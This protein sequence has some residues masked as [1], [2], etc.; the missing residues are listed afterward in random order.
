M[1]STRWLIV[2]VCAVLVFQAAFVAPSPAAA[3]E[4]SAPVVQPSPALEPSQP[5][6]APVT[7][8]ESPRP[9]PST[10]PADDEIVPSEAP[11]TERTDMR[12][13]ASRTFEQAD[14]TFISELFSDAIFY[15]PEGSADWQPIDLTFAPT[16]AEGATAAVTRAPAQ[17][18]LFGADAAEGFLRLTGDGHSLR[19]S[20]PEGTEP[21]MAGTRPQIMENGAYVDYADFLPGGIGL[22]VFPRADGFKSFFVIPSRPA[23]NTFSLRIDAPGLSLAPDAER[24][25]DLVFRDSAGQVVGRIPRPFMLDSSVLETAEGGRGGGL[26]SEAV[27]QTAM[28]QADGSYLLTL[29]V[30]PAFLDSAVYPV[31]VDPTTT[32]FPTGATTAN[33]TFANSQTP[34]TNYN[35]YQR[36]DSPFYNEQWHGNTPGTAYYNEVYIRFNDIAETLG[37][38]LITDTSLQLYPYWQYNHSE[39]RSSWVERIAE[40]WGPGTLDWNDRPATDM[41]IGEFQTKEDVWSD[42][43]L[44]AYVQDVVNGTYPN[45]GLMLHANTLGSG[46]W[47]RIVSSN[48]STLK[49]KLVVSWTA[50]AGPTV[51]YPN[52]GGET[53]SRTLTWSLPAS[54]TQSAFEVQLDSDTG[55]SPTVYSSG[56]IS[57]TPGTIPA[58]MIPT[59]TTLTEGSTYYWRVRVKYGVNTTF[60][61]WSSTNGSFVYRQGATLGLPGHNT[62]ESFDLGSGDSALANVSTGNLVI[63]HPIVSLPVRG[64]AFDLSLTYNSHST[65]N[66]GTGPGWR[67]N[68]MR[69]LAE[70][71]NGDVV[72]TAADGSIHT[73]TK[74]STVGTVTT[75]TRPSTVYATL[76]KDTS[77]ANEWKLVYRDQSVDEFNLVSS[78]GLLAKQADRHGNAITFAY[79]TSSNRLQTATDPAGRVVDFAWNTGVSPARLTSITDWAYVSGGVIQSTATGSRREYR[80][81][82]DSNGYLIGWSNPLNTSGSCPTMASNLTCLAYTNNLLTAITKR[83]TIATLSGGAIGTSSRDISTQVTY[84]GNEVAEVRDAEQANAS[85]TGTTFT[86]IADKQLRVVRQGTPASTTTYG[87][88]SSTDNLG[89]VE[90]VWRKLGSTDIEQLTTWSSTYPTEPA[91]VTDNADAALST[92]ARTVSYTY[93]DPP[94]MGLVKQITAPLTGTTSKTTEYTYNANNDV[95]QIIVAGPSGSTTTRYCYTTSGCSTSATDLTLKSVIESYGDGSKGGSGGNATDV[96]TDYLYDANGLLTLETRWNYDEDGTLLDSRAIGYMY[97]TNNKG[98]RVKTITNYVSGTVTSPGEDV[99][100]NSSTGAYTDL[101]TVHGFDTAGNEISVE[102]PRRGIAV[103]TGQPSLVADDYVTRYEYDALNRQTRFQIARDPIDTATPKFSTA[104]YDELGATREATDLGGLVSA[105]N[106]DR[107]GRPL[108]TYEDPVGAS[109]VE[110]SVSTYDAAGRLQT[111]KDRR[112]IGSAS[113]GW[114]NFAYDALGRLVTQTEAHSGDAGD[115][116]VTTQSYDGLDRRT[117]LVSGAGAMGQTTTYRYDLGGRV[118]EQDDEFTCTRTTYD[119]R[120]L[121]QTAIEGLT[122]GA[123]CTGTG[124]RTVAN[125]H[126]GLGRTTRAEVTLGAGNGDYDSHTF[127]AA[128]NVLGSVSYVAAGQTSTTVVYDINGLDQ[129]HREV[130]SDGSIGRTMFDAARN[131][132]DRCYWAAAPDEICKP[133]GSSYT[134]PPTRLTSTKFDA[135]NQRIELRDAAT[136][137][138]TTYSPANNYLVGAYYVPT[139]GTKELQTLYEYDE[140]HRLKTVTHQVCTIASSHSCP[141]PVPTGIARYTYDTNDNRASVAESTDGST[142][143]PTPI[144]Y[145]YDAQSRL[146][147][148]ESGG[149]CNSAQDDEEFEYDVAGNRTQAGSPGSPTKFGYEQLTGGQLCKVGATSPSDCSGANVTYD[150][151]GRTRSWNA[152]WFTYDDDGRLVTACKSSTC[153]STADKATFVYDGEGRRTEIRTDLAGSPPETVTAMRY[154]GDTVVEERVGGVVTRQYLPDESGRILKMIIPVGQ[155]NPGAYVVT[156]NG[157]GDAMALWRIKS[158][159]AVEIANA[160]NY[161]SWGTPTVSSSHVNSDTSQ[162]YGDLGFRFLYVGAHDVQWDNFS[163]LGLH[164]MH[165][166]HY[167]P[168]IGRFL[169]PDPIAAESN[170]YSYAASNPQTFIDPEGTFRTRDYGGLAFSGVGRAAYGL[171]RNL[172]G[173]FGRTLYLVPPTAFKLY[174]I[175]GGGSSHNHRLEPLLKLFGSEKTLF[176]AIQRIVDLRYMI[177]TLTRS[178][179]GIFRV[180]IR[181]FGHPVE[182]TGRVMNGSLYVSNFWIKG[183]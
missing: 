6:P 139:T 18:S 16:D 160:Y 43:D 90:S 151:A 111:Q 60:S 155:S 143:N 177:N 100:P 118:T 42:F 99:T 117:Q 179:D 138:T 178:S 127:D 136:E 61:A 29:T 104:Q 85:A 170:W 146:V 56:T 24:E 69:R 132:T 164:Y 3:Q 107:V 51:V 157:H 87:Y 65:A 175:F 4:P 7:P 13:D 168:A 169:Q 50:F 53:S 94:Q 156:W 121:A 12:T 135:R 141:T 17:V 112:Q 120:D 92:P 148:T 126:D 32:T 91:S 119:Y 173:W 98:R 25:Q 163:G 64:G 5:S 19:L 11:G 153:A 71:G 70:L 122:A 62:F 81:F 73:F 116:L 48:N 40:T 68:A 109:A 95:T 59:T 96:T 84:R 30:D 66:A 181:V 110:T 130:R 149:A 74:I 131:A 176:L 15:Q 108:A 67:L 49:P 183:R 159:G 72:L 101:T 115:E 142:Q 10:P 124:L 182:V 57:G 106:Y 37:S 93:W 134:N 180:D 172:M 125:T 128:G 76:T 167:S 41:T 54:S 79:Y 97:D 26:Y 77:W 34:N 174:Y 22:R 1:S 144:N 75:Y 58:H 31:Y 140:R 78:E 137:S 133:V 158:G 39:W 83:Q 33:D 103:I 27:T 123:Q 8:P 171:L 152:W 161:S 89:R 44:D 147:A 114:T 46:G 35:S 162:P 165:A 52:G 2:L 166:R 28:V 63:S 14:G 36:P 105:S 82:Y 45:H 23:S 102:D 20:L 150:S 55:F 88:V 9:A 38:G 154:H 129:A 86:R 80:L 145:C 113:L 21:G 47:K